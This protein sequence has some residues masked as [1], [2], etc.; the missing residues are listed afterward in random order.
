MKFPAQLVLSINHNMILVQEFRKKDWRCWWKI[1]DTSGL[2]KKT[3]Y[4]T[5][6]V[7]TENKIPDIS[8]LVSSDILN[9]KVTNF[10]IKR[11]DT[12]RLVKKTYQNTKL[13]QIETKYQ[14]LLLW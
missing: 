6:I 7:Q 2:V 9:I 1:L 5:K 3:D 11:P 13:T 12:R 14:I 4:D 8:A 10:G